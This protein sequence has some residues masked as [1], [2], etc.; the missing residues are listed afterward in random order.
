M[1]ARYYRKNKE[2]LK[3]RLAKNIKIF[4]N[5]RK[6]KR[7]NIVMKNIEIFLKNRKTNI[8]IERKKYLP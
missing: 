5:K 6:T 7:V 8:K 3:K 2:R 1:L 4:L